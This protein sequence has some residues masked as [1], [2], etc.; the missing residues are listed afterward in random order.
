[1]P[2]LVQR[3]DA[4]REARDLVAEHRLGLAPAVQHHQ[5]DP[6]SVVGGPLSV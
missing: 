2:A 3:H 6:V 5:R 1:V 4:A